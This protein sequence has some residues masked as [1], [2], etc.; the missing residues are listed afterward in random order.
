[1]KLSDLKANPKNPRK[2]ADWQKDALK[3]SIE[4]FGD[5]SGFIYN[6][7][8]KQLEGGHQRKLVMPEDAEVTI[9]K[10]YPTPTRTG[11]V[12]EGYVILAGERYAYREVDWDADT[13]RAA[14]IAANKHGGE[15]DDALLKQALAQLD[16]ELLELTGFH[17]DELDKLVEQS[18]GTEGL[19]DEDDVPEEVEA[20]T[21]PGDLWILGEHRLLCGDCTV[22][23][24]VERLM[25]GQKADMVFTDPPYNHAEKDALVSQSVRQAMKRLAESEWD[26]SFNFTKTLECLEGILS[27]DCSIYICTSW[28]LAGEIWNYYSTRSTTNGYCV[29][30][31]PNPMPSLMKRH[32]TWA[33]ELICYAT[34]GKHTFNFPDEGHARNV[35]EIQKNQKNDL[36]PTMKPVEIPEKAIVHS[37][38]QGMIVW[39]GFLGSGPTLIACEKTGR[40]C[41][42]MEIDPHY[43]DV[44]VARYEKFTG[45]K[46]MRDGKAKVR[47]KEAS[48]VK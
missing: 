9:E 31:K 22:E 48:E 37:S 11:T 4:A 39:D 26:K 14:N 13:A 6:R 32:W 41:Y 20:I 29:W 43:C 5:L 8:S 10:K 27:K 2:I 21:K 46:G 40:K 36:H 1:M 19:C 24:N 33:S 3:R 23:A 34:R 38:K 42:G 45:K 47:K 25:A 15:F 35:W 18:G 44:I 16:D 7:R 30:S 12:A 17:E 28:H